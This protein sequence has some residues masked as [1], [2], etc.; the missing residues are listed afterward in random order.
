[1]I[2]ELVI[3][4]ETGDKDIFEYSSRDDAE[5]SMRGFKVAFGEQI[6]WCGVRKKM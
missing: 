6:T 3:V 1:M 5:E 2:Y 4:W